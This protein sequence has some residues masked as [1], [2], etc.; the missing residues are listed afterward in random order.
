[1]KTV[2]TLN[3]GDKLF[4]PTTMEIK[5]SVVSEI[6]KDCDGI[7]V[8]SPDY[9][10]RIRDSDDNAAIATFVTFEKRKRIYYLRMEDAIKVQN[11]L[12]NEY[13]VKL[14]D[15]VAKC[16]KELNDFTLKYFSK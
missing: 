14:Q 1:M 2:N 12:Q 11:K 10:A 5:E 8:G 7:K 4:L 9:Y 16:I 6:I 15:A 3:V 13:L